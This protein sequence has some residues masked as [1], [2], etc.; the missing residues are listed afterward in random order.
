MDH[1]GASLK[2]SIYLLSG[3]WFAIVNSIKLGKLKHVGH[4]LPTGDRD[5][6]RAFPGRQVAHQEGQK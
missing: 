3:A 5:V 4:S 1:C 2:L 6:A